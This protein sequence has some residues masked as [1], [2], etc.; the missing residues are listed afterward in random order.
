MAAGMGSRYGGNKQIDGISAEDDIIMDFSLYDAYQAGFRRACFI[1]KHDF[2]EVFRAHM[3]ERAGKYFECSYVFQEMDD[4][5]EGYTVPEGRTKP[6]G[7]T[8]AVLAA[9][10]AVDAP[11][12]VINADDY[13][14]KDAFVLM[15]DYLKKYADATHACM[16]GFSIENTLSDHGTVTRGICRAENGKL[17][18][19]EES[20]KVGRLE[21]GMIGAEN[22]AGE[23]HRYPEGT[24][25][26][27]N[28]WGFGPEF[29]Q[30]M[31]GKLAATLDEVLRDN[32]LKG[33]CLLPTCVDE[34]IREGVITVEVLHSHD[35]WFGVTYKED[36]QVVVDKF[37]AMKDAGVYPRDLWA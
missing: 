30:Y 35:Q 16:I 27:M 8:H 24:L 3:E 26:S 15:Y 14:G 12:A 1:I 10:T 21:D 33:E 11:F 28:M 17:A 22:G 36:K 7:T 34:A 20:F 5:P 32:P 31:Q 13:Y 23:F 29:M 4:L 25:V 2:E 18:E 37:A 9:R 6:W 19:I